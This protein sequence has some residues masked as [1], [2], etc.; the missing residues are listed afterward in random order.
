MICHHDMTRD[1]SFYYICARS[2]TPSYAFCK[3]CELYNEK[4]GKIWSLFFEL[5]FWLVP[6]MF[7]SYYGNFDYICVTRINCEDLDVNQSNVI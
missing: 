5:W 7:M 1:E 4:Q 6:S 2:V 3:M